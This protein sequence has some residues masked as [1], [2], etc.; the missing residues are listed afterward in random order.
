MRV[1]RKDIA[2]ATG[3]SL[4]TVGMILGGSGERYH[5][6]TR[7]RVQ[8]AA[9]RLGYQTVVSARALR[10]QRSFLLG[11]LFSEMNAF[12]ASPFLRG[13]Q[14][15]I[16]PTDYS[17]LVFFNRTEA[18]QESSLNHCLARGVD[19]LL[20]NCVVDETGSR[21]GGFVER[22]AGLKIPVMEFFG[23]Q[24]P[25]APRADIDNRHTGKEGVRHLLELGHRRIVHLTH[26]RYRNR[27]LHRDAC[28]IAEGY[29]KAMKDA[30]LKSRIIAA[31]LDYAHFASEEFVVAGTAGFEKLGSDDDRPT[32]V[33]CY[34]DL[35]A[36]GLVRASKA[37]GLRVP[38]DLSVIGNND[39][40]LASVVSP[41]LSSM[42]LDAYQIGFD[43]ASGLIGALDGETLANIDIC[44]VV[45]P[46]Q[47][48]GPVPLG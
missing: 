22:L 44:P 26:R 3:V 20:V 4:S 32:A 30:G 27:R 42:R 10:L 1:T 16:K 39:L 36:L 6:D 12:H 14:Q 17:P 37:C 11:V 7:R 24:V 31:D 38:E 45:V 15:A 34:N 13:V 19:A 23:S 43:G 28:E 46:R 40:M 9:E 48:T 5:P 41:S 25:G 8:E 33:A 29:R 47:S 35:M 2:K 18:D 21:I